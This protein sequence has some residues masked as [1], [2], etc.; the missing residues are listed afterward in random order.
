MTENFL[1]AEYMDAQ[2]FK[3]I[4]GAILFVLCAIYFGMAFYHISKKPNSDNSKTK[5]LNKQEYVR[6]N[7]DVFGI[8]DC[9]AADIKNVYL[10][11]FEKMGYHSKK[12]QRGDKS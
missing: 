11:P 10:V 8:K 5:P 7:L 4:M 12:V 2:T 3:Y 1:F 9:E 6:Q